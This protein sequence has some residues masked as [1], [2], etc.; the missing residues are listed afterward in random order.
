MKRVWLM[1]I[2]TAPSCTL[3]AAKNFWEE[4]PYQQQEG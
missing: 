3:Y 1:A 2:L 4:K